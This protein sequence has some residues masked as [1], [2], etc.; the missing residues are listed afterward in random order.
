MIKWKA[1]VHTLQFFFFYNIF[2]F[3]LRFSLESFCHAKRHDEFI[4][5]YPPI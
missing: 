3:E 1:D 4:I 2:S 5:T